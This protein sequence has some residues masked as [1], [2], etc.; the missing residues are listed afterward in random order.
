MREYA[1]GCHCGNIRYRLECSDPSSEWS[2][3]VCQCAFCK[4]LGAAYVSGSA[5][6][7]TVLYASLIDRY[8]FATKTAEFIR[9][10]KCGI[11]PVVTD[12]TGAQ[13]LGI[14]NVRTLDE[15]DFAA[16]QFEPMDYDGESETERAARRADRWTTNTTLNFVNA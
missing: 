11:M 15:V 13:L 1:G 9:C 14:V 16:S 10:G 8:Q 12:T 3:R 4:K 5:L 7:I 6:E 2:L